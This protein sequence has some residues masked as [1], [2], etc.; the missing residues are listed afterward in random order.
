MESWLAARMDHLATLEARRGW[1]RPLTFTNWVT[2]DPLSHPGEPLATEDL[3]SIDATHVT[4]TRAWPGGVF[5]SYHV[6]PYYPDFLSLGEESYAGYLQALRAAHHGTQPVMITEFGVPSSLGV[7]H[8]AP[9]GRDQGAHSERLA[10]AIDAAMLRE[11]RS[12]GMA[13]GV[14]FEWIDEWFKHTW[15]TQPLELPFARRALWRNDLTNEEH[16]GVLSADPVPGRPHA[17]GHGIRAQTD[18]EALTLT[19]PARAS[20]LTVGLDARPGAGGGLPGSP[21]VASQAD[22]AI[23]VSGAKATVLQ[24]ASWEPVG[25]LYG[26]RDGVAPAAPWQPARQ[27]IS[28]PLT[29][30]DTGEAFPAQT[31]EVPALPVRRGHGLLTI[32]LPWALLGFSDP[33][34]LSVYVP[35][36]DGSVGTARVAA[37]GVTVAAP[38][39]TPVT[40]KPLRLHGWNRVTRWQERRKRSWSTLARAF[41]QATR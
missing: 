28:H 16:F 36:A 4:A 1:S 24:A 34:S 10:G 35:R 8:A 5:A 25:L 38:P 3:V 39:G 19:I 9:L 15:N 2:D 20:A 23:Q 41:R 27:L 40:A 32:R 17:L 33:S 37:I 18:P 31:R 26:A 13:G 29:R 30:P 14:L 22:V 21:G 11:I 12:A 6:Y 7:A